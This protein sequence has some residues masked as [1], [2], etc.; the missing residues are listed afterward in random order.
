MHSCMRGT[1]THGTARHITGHSTGQHHPLAQH[2]TAYSGHNLSQA[3]WGYAQHQW[4]TEYHSTSGLQAVLHIP[5]AHALGTAPHGTTRHSTAWHGTAWHSTARHGTECRSMPQHGLPGHCIAH[6]AIWITHKQRP[7]PQP[8][9]FAPTPAP[10]PFLAAAPALP[11]DIRYI[12]RPV[13]F[14]VDRPVEKV[15]ERPVERGE[16]CCGLEPNLQLL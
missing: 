15:V 13:P 3:S 9:A 12:D 2:G 10:G 4:S 14:Y 5:L 16:Q 6:Q 11:P 8:Q 1:T 7:K